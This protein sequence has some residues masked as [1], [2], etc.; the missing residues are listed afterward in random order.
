[1]FLLS[2]AGRINFMISFGICLTPKESKYVTLLSLRSLELGSAVFTY[3][4]TQ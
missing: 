4:A 3:S 1:M 2:T